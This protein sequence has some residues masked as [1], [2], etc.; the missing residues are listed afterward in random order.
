MICIEDKITEIIFMADKSYQV[1]NIVMTHGSHDRN[2]SNSHHVI[3]DYNVSMLPT[4]HR[5]PNDHQLLL[6]GNPYKALL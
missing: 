4:I 3:T 6:E 5:S 1:F 2:S